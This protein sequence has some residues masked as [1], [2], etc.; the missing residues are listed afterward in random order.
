MENLHN[1][2]NKHLTLSERIKIE[3]SLNENYSIRKIS[4]EINRPPS[5]IVY[6]ISNR[7][8]IRNQT[9]LMGKSKILIVIN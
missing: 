3:A 7:K 9:I 8:I 4:R 2:K 6:E 5:T 1:K